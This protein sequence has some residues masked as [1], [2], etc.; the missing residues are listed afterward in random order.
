MSLTLLQLIFVSCA[1]IKEFSGVA[2]AECDTSKYK[3][4]AVTLRQSI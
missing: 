3:G 2:R 1:K 4:Y